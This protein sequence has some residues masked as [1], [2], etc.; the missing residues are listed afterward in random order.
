MVCNDLPLSTSLHCAHAALTS[1]LAG[2]G[3][4]VQRTTSSPSAAA[5]TAIIAFEVTAFWWNNANGSQSLCSEVASPSPVARAS[6]N[7]STAS[8]HRRRRR[9]AAGTLLDCYGD[10]DGRKPKSHI[11][12]N[13]ADA[14]DLVGEE[15]TVLQAGWLDARPRRSLGP[16]LRP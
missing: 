8:S 3:L 9:A 4:S 5:C 1:S 10:A 7:G 2:Y 11:A 13:T 14:V 6:R 15:L 12:P 16:R